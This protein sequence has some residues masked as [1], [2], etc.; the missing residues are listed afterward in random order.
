MWQF[1]RDFRSSDAFQIL[2]S[3][4]FLSFRE[5]RDI[6][7]Y[8]ESREAS[9][10]LD[11]T[12]IYAGSRQSHPRYNIANFMWRT[13]ETPRQHQENK[14]YARACFL[15]LLFFA[16][17]QE[18]WL[19]LEAAANKELEENKRKKRDRKN[20]VQTGKNGAIKKIT[21]Y[22]LNSPTKIDATSF[23][24]YLIN[25]HIQTFSHGVWKL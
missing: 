22:R 19:S 18:R 1:K 17:F 23:Y 8:G 16:S 14:F 24:S 7:E 10:M 11:L 3:T 15:I 25:I 5:S 4:I 9:L 21:K 2:L 20:A 6:I 12:I 13:R